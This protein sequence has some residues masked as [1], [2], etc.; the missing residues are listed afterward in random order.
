M[1]ELA[2]WAGVSVSNPPQQ[3]WTLIRKGKGGG[4]IHWAYQNKEASKKITKKTCPKQKHPLNLLRR[5]IRIRSISQK[6]PWF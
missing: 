1:D 3:K 4:E 5:T 6:A 2:M